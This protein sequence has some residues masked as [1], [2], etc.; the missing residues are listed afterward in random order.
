M[1]KIDFSK[2]EESKMEA[3]ENGVSE[4]VEAERVKEAEKQSKTYSDG[5]TDWML[6]E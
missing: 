4:K 1:M 5:L 6:E 2:L 3:L